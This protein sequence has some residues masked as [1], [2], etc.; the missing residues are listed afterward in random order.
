MPEY[1]I[2]Q[3]NFSILHVTVQVTLQVMITS[4]FTLGPA[5]I[6]SFKTSF[7]QLVWQSVFSIDIHNHICETFTQLGLQNEF[8]SKL[9]GFCSD[10][11]SNMQGKIIKLI[12]NEMIKKFFV[13]L[14]MS[15]S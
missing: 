14:F 7:Y 11:A 10:R 15:T 8:K 5:Q 1:K 4:L 12:E 9:V 6:G 13:C 3:L 2:H